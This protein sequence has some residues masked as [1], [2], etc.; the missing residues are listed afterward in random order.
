MLEETLKV[1]VAGTDCPGLSLVPSWFH[2][3]VIGP[4]ALAGVQLVVPMLKASEM[5]LPVFFT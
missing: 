1:N 2:V 3:K 5:P 4:Q